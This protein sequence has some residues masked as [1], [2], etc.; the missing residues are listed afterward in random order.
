M[1]RVEC[2]QLHFDV[3]T[4]TIG[5]PFVEASLT[6]QTGAMQEITDAGNVGFVG[7]PVLGVELKF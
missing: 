6:Q 4:P 7:E 5:K 1:P 3:N 2:A